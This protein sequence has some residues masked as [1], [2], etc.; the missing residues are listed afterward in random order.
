MD[1]EIMFCINMSPHTL[2]DVTN[3]FPAKQHFLEISVFTIQGKEQSVAGTDFIGAQRHNDNL[4]EEVQN[5]EKAQR[6][7]KDV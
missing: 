1:V 6:V 7:T 5:I 3:N 2:N 4:G